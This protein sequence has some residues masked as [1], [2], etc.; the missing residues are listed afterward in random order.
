MCV[1]TTADGVWLRTPFYARWIPWGAIERFV[2]TPWGFYDEVRVEV[3]GG[4]T[5]RAPLV[6]GRTMRWER[7][8]TKDVLSALNADLVAAREGQTVA[9]KL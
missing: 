1:A 9:A 8:G 5:Y 3:H 6:Q 7:G 4:R 2:A